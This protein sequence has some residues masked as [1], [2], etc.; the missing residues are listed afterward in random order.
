MRIIKDKSL[1]LSLNINNKPQVNYYSFGQKML[2]THGP[3]K[4][5]TII[6]RVEKK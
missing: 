6:V 3:Q 5:K 4:K 2:F 1:W